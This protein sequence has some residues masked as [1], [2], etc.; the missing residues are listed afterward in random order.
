L[1]QPA[2][3]AALADAA[4]EAIGAAHEWASLEAQRQSGFKEVGGGFSLETSP[5]SI[6]IP[7][8][9]FAAVL[10]NAA[11]VAE[12][13]DVAAAEGGG[14]YN[15]ILGTGGVAAA[16]GEVQG[17]DSI[18][19][20]HDGTAAVAAAAVGPGASSS[21]S[22]AAAALLSDPKIAKMLTA[23]AEH[24]I[25]QGLT[26]VHCISLDY[27]IVS[28]TTTHVNT[29]VESQVERYSERLQH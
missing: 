10:V 25:R 13:T 19:M 28:P 2:S 29:S 1:D 9:R 24:P 12:S 22:S 6:H 15:A 5:V 21:S 7:L 26:L 8:H 18:H 11:V 16:A 3:A 4:R 14:Y 27:D 17:R 20:D 23:L